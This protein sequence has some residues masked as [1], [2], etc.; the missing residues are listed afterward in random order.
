MSS[1]SKARQP[2]D[3]SPPT[4]ATQAPPPV[5]S[6]SDVSITG[7]C[8]GSLKPGEVLSKFA[9]AKEQRQGRKENLLSRVNTQRSVKRTNHHPQ[10]YRMPA[11]PH[12]CRHHSHS[13]YKRLQ[14][15]RWGPRV[16]HL[17]AEIHEQHR[18]WKADES[19]EHLQKEKERERIIKK[20]RDADTE[21]KQTQR[22]VEL[23]RER[24][25][26]R[27]IRS[28]RN[29]WGERGRNQWAFW[30]LRFRGNRFK[31]SKRRSG[32]WLCTYMCVIILHV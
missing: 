5:P 1:T 15:S 2:V 16:A 11:H 31:W 26:Q 8:W 6:L 23:V 32:V 9:R 3:K 30:W 13:H 19:H 21:G 24:P 17:V 7:R 25:E 18:F 10:A 27:E 22:G 4:T 28:R 12:R 14:T 20:L 29:G